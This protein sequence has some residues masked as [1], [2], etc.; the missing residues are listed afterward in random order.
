MMFNP[1]HIYHEITAAGEAW[2]DK[3]SAADLLEE[4]RKSVLAELINSAEGPSVAAKENAAL[5]DPAYKLHITQMV[6]ARR[7]ANIARVRYDAVRV[8]AE[9]RRSQESTKRAEMGMR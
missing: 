6:A 1:D 5:A 3:E 4:T 7:E 8:L 9:L 2:A